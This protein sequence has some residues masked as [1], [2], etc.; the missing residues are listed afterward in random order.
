MAQKKKKSIP[1]LRRKQITHTLPNVTEI[2]IIGSR[3][4]MTFI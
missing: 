2:L 1:L 4:L 3:C